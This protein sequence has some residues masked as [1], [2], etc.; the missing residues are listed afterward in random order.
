[1]RAPRIAAADPLLTVEDLMQRLDL[2]TPS[3]VNRWLRR[4][5]VPFTKPGRK[6]YVRQSDL[7]AALERCAMG[8]HDARATAHLRRVG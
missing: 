1:V 7:D 2:K 4:N 3:G 6:F 8:N 5:Q